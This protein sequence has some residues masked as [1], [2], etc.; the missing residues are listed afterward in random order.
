MKEPF[1]SRAARAVAKYG[2]K[3]PRWKVQLLINT[4]VLR[5]GKSVPIVTVGIDLAKNVFAVQG[6]DAAG[7]P[8]LAPLAHR[9][10]CL[11]GYGD[12]FRDIFLIRK[13]AALTKQAQ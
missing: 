1:P 6:V 3:V 11:R 4:L 9:H 2:I 13:I 7:E 10:A 5:K 12:T 8:T